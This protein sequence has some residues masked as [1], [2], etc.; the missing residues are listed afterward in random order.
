MLHFPATNPGHDG[1]DLLSFTIHSETGRMNA[2]F[3]A[4]LL[5]VGT[6]NGL[7]LEYPFLPRE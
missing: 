3:D 2:C 6:Q 1:G 5:S 7:G 4:G